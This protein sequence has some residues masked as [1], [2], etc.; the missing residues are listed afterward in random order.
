MMKIHGIFARLQ[1]GDKIG[2]TLLMIMLDVQHRL[3]SN[4]LKNVA[5][6]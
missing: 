5:E 1:R 2:V 6:L 4:N 3:S